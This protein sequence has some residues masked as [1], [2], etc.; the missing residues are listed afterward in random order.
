MKS[1]ILVVDDEPIVRQFIAR[2]LGTHGY[3]VLLAANAAEAVKVFDQARGCGID[4]LITEF[5]LPGWGGEA[6]TRW[7]RAKQNRLPVLYMTGQSGLDTSAPVLYKP[8]TAYKLLETVG[9][10][11]CVR[12]KAA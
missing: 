6:L 8:F 10:Y 7:L 4:L 3:D 1:R 5:D 12:P 2:A 9:S 11:C